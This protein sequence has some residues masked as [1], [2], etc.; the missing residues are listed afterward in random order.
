MQP[1]NVIFNLSLGDA[2]EKCELNVK[3]DATACAR[4]KAQRGEWEQKREEGR[5][6]WDKHIFQNIICMHSS[7]CGSRQASATNSRAFVRVYGQT[8]HIWIQIK[9]WRC[10]DISLTKSAVHISNNSFKLQ[11]SPQRAKNLS[12]IVHHFLTNTNR[13]MVDSGNQIK[14]WYYVPSRVSGMLSLDRAD[15]GSTDRTFNDSG[16]YSKGQWMESKR[17]KASWP[18]TSP[19]QPHPRASQVQMQHGTGLCESEFLCDTP[20]THRHFIR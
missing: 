16:C 18:M 3:S 11:L 19:T 5:R 10:R 13:V 20:E 15:L 6:Q 1:I 17:W 4:P 8:G 12:L 2:L 7:C 14:Y 9:Q